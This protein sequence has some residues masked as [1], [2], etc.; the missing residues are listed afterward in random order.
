MKVISEYIE[1]LFI[2]IE[3]NEK[4]VQLKEELLANAEDRYGELIAQGHAENEVI[5]AVIAEFGSI[6]ELLYEMDMKKAY[7]SDTGYTMEEVTVSEAQDY[8]TKQ[9]RSAL[10]I[11][12]GVVACLLGVN[13]MF[14]FMFFFGENIGGVFG[15]GTVLVGAAI[16]VPLF[17]IGGMRIDQVNKSLAGRLIPVNVRRFAE[18]K[19]NEFRRSFVLSISLGV[20]FC[21]L[22]VLPLIFL[23]ELV[24]T[25]KSEMLGLSLMFPLLALGVFLFIYAG[26]IYGSCE[27][28]QKKNFYVDTEDETVKKSVDAPQW[29]RTLERV[30]WPIVAA[31]FLFQ[32]FILGNWSSSWMLFPIAGFAF[33]ILSSFFE[34]E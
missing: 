5:G 7:E 19:H 17:I 34:N 28:L 1:S 27:T 30:Y 26:M 16:G 25:E 31:V 24:G 29:Y 18:K 12:L 13:L 20:V 3:P 4:I 33:W 23:S 2:G 14:V 10:E 11:A 15:V 9:R 8:L 32:S 22:S 6:D 21:V